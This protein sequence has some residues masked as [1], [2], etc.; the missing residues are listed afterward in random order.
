MESH[1]ID[2]SRPHSAGF[3]LIASLLMLLLMSGLAIGLM[4]MVNTEGKVGSGD[5]QNNVAYHAA[6]GGIE[7]MYS[8]LSATLQNAQA[9]TAA[10]ICNVGGTTNQPNMIGVTWKDYSV[11]PGTT[12]TSTCPATLTT[13]WGQVSSGPN[14][15]LFAQIIPVNMLATAAVPGGQEVSMSRNAQVALIPVF[16]FGMFC[17]SDCS[18]YP[19]SPMTFQGRVHSNGDFY[20][21][22]QGGSTLTFQSKVSVYGNVVRTILPNTNTAGA[23]S[24]T[25]YVPTSSNANACSTTTTNCVALAAVG[26]T[27][28]WGDGSLQGAGGN[29]PASAYSSAWAGFSNTT[30]HDQVINGNYG[31]QA[32]GQ[33]GTGAKK[34]SMPFVNGTNFPYQIIRRPPAGESAMSILG[35][36]REYNMAQIRVLLSDDP[37]EFQNGTGATDA[38][39]VRLANVAQTSVTATQWGVAMAAGNYNPAFGTP[40]GG[41]NF[42]LNFATA[43]DS[44]PLPS[45]C[46]GAACAPDDWINPPKPWTS[47]MATA[48]GVTFAAPV[49]ATAPMNW[50]NG[51]SAAINLCPPAGSPASLAGCPIPATGAYPFYA[52]PNPALP[53]VSSVLTAYNSANSDSWN[54][55]DG[56]LR[57]EYLNNSGVWIPVTNEWLALGF[58]R[59]VTAPTANGAGLPASWNP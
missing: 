43:S 41:D 47:T 56:W 22:T 33:Q 11:M 39:N 51:P 10:Q 6:E 37:A 28:P 42:Y 30:T 34:L 16:Q 35:Q 5:L 25:V 57:V 54:L 15:G 21:F 20:P 17:E 50:N 18:I 1:H 4:M 40:P 59:G 23:Y 58:A 14:Q 32:V 53:L 8:D 49:P 26:T 2:S 55:I 45:T 24:G 27:N 13:Q 19:G 52:P 31:N 9:P 3:T 7:K 38:D 44:V 46:A 48:D 29:P 12:Q 36:S